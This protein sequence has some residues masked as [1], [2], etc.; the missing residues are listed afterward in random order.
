M[1]LNTLFLPKVDGLQTESSD[2]NSDPRS[3]HDC[4]DVISNRE[5][6]LEGRHGHP[7]C[8][9]SNEGNINSSND[10]TALDLYAFRNDTEKVYIA[11]YKRASGFRFFWI[12]QA[13]EEIQPASN[14]ATANITTYQITRSAQVNTNPVTFSHDQRLLFMTDN[15]VFFTK[16]TY[17]INPVI[18]ST[19]FPIIRTI[20][21]NPEWRATANYSSALDAENSHWLIPGYQVNVKI[22]IEVETKFND[23][24]SRRIESPPSR[25][26]EI[27]QLNPAN[28]D[29]RLR[30]SNMLITVSDLTISSIPADYKM[31]LKI[32]RT[33]Q[34]IIGKAAPTEY[35]LASPEIQ[36]SSTTIVNSANSSTYIRLTANDDFI[37]GLEHLYNDTSLGGF[38]VTNHLPVP[39]KNVT[40]FRNYY[41]YSNI[42][43]PALTTIGLTKLPDSEDRL[44]VKLSRSDNLG[45]ITGIIVFTSSLTPTPG[46]GEVSIPSNAQTVSSPYLPLERDLSFRGIRPGLANTTSDLNARIR[47]VPGSDRGQVEPYGKI[48]QVQFVKGGAGSQNTTTVR[49]YPDTTGFDS[50]RF[51]SPGIA[52]IV[53]PTGRVRTFFNYDNIQKNT[54]TTNY[55]DFV[56]SITEAAV[57]PADTTETLYVYYIPGEQIK[58]LPLYI[59]DSYRYLSLLPCKN[60][61]EDFVAKPQITA[62]IAYRYTTFSTV[63]TGISYSYTPSTVTLTFPSAHGLFNGESYVIST[64]SSTTALLDG[65]FVITVVSSTQITYSKVNAG[66]NNG[67]IVTGTITSSVNDL[68]VNPIYSGLLN[69]PFSFLLNDLAVRICDELNRSM[70]SAAEYIRCQGGDLDQPGVVILESLNPDYETISLSKRST[71][72][73]GNNRALSSYSIT[74][75]EVTITTTIAHP[76]LTG[77]LVTIDS[78]ENTIDGEYTITKL[79]GTT[80]KYSKTLANIG[81]TV[82]T[83]FADK[84]QQCY[85]PP[86]PTSPVAGAIYG[87]FAKSEKASNAFIISKLN[88]PEVV[89]TS[90][91]SIQQSVSGPYYPARVG[92]PNKAIVACAATQDSVYM[93]KEDGVARVAIGVNS[94]IPTIQTINLFDTTV[95]CNSA[96]SVQVI[97]DSVFL[98]AQ[99]GVYGIQGNSISKLSRNV[100][101]DLKTTISQCKNN[102][103]LEKVRSFANQAKN[104]Y[105]VCIPISSTTYVTYILNTLTMRWLRW[106][107]QFDGAVVDLDGRLTTL[108]TLTEKNSTTTYIRQDQYTNSQPRNE[109]DQFDESYT[110]TAASAVD[111]GLVRTL[112]EPGIGDYYYRFRFYDSVKNQFTT[113]QVYYFDGTT[114]YKLTDVQRIGNNSITVTF[115]TTPPAFLTSHRLIVG[116]NMMIDF[117]PFSANNPSTLKQFSGFHIHTEESVI[118]LGVQF[119]TETN[120]SS[121]VRMVSSTSADRTVYRCFIPTVA[122]R[123]R[124]LYRKITHTRPFQ[125]CAIPAQAII[126]R[127]TGS[128]RVQKAQ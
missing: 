69:R 128:E 70:N 92:S 53:D 88:L 45:D 27:K 112:L 84:V 35:Y 6:F 24:G 59:G 56:Y 76:Y 17:Q 48:T 25:I 30:T 49:V 21:I 81:T 16:N 111:V 55:V 8:R 110:L 122:V 87:V 41:I 85:E 47:I 79:T 9:L 33:T 66:T 97:N 95:F 64:G 82:I 119:R 127:D 32:Y 54:T 114:Y 18:Y 126:F 52:V 86:V 107:N 83:G 120:V 2:I 20:S 65:T 123:G 93:L 99:D 77:D 74:A 1:P 100:E 31:Y 96:G 121:N 13:G 115:A 29:T 102:G 124:Y 37:E 98:L 38:G 60:Q 72:N 34:F 78:S 104:L 40:P 43:L 50:N 105:G 4:I 113:K 91:T 28:T 118:D 71:F 68:A 44:T 73:L 36:I 80:F 109:L 103:L 26:Y 39:S 116:V 62:T 106:S 101:T 117:Q 75:N 42:S 3:L 5:D 10:H 125:I 14:Q 67:T 11:T 89:P 57:T 108:C 22:V 90:D 94:S 15:G 12:S 63:L 19:T 51:V 23:D 46:M 58:S 61:L 7:V